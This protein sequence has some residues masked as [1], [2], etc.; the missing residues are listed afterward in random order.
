MLLVSIDIEDAQALAQNLSE[1]LQYDG[2][3]ELAFWEPLLCRLN[4]AIRHAE[5]S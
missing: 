4:T 2:E 1:H 3:E 5:E